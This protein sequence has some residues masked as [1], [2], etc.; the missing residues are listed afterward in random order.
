VK[1]I[2]RE[3]WEQTQP[4]TEREKGSLTDYLQAHQVPARAKMLPTNWQQCLTWAIQDRHPSREA[5]GTRG[6][7]EK[8]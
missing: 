5:G 4:L 8:P 2:T 7:A 1:R 6:G 3:M